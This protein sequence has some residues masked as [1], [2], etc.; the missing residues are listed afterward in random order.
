MCLGLKKSPP[1]IDRNVVCIIGLRFRFDVGLTRIGVY[2]TAAN[3]MVRFV[4][5][6]ELIMNGSHQSV[7]QQTWSQKNGGCAVN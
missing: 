1:H 5:G 6:Y 3:D 2:R 7:V 4:I